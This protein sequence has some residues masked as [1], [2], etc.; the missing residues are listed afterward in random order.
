MKDKIY[1]ILY[2]MIQVFDNEDDWDNLNLNNQVDAQITDNNGLVLFEDLNT[3]VYYIDAYRDID[4][5]NYYSNYLQG[6]A[7][8]ILDE[9]LINE[10]NIYVE[11]LTSEKKIKNKK[12]AIRY[13]EKSSKEEHDRIIKAYK[14]KK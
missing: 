2:Q 4:G 12:Y 3:I 14:S 7:T 13:I 8:E 1:N 5:T 10:Y 6:Y 11:V 9:G